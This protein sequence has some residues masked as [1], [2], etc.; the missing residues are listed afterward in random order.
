MDKSWLHEKRSSIRYLYGLHNFLDFAF[1]TVAPHSHR[2]TNDS[3][4]G[5]TSEG[6]AEMERKMRGTS[7]G[8]AEAE[9]KMRGTSEG[10]QEEERKMRGSTSKKTRGPTTCLKT[11]GLRDEERLPIRL[12]MF[13]QPIGCNRAALSTYLGTLARNAHLVPIKYTCW[14]QLQLNESEDW[15]DDMWGTVTADPG[16]GGMLHIIRSDF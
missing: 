6:K 14:K 13:G 8:R 16:I 5:E 2:E 11:H 9:R 1:R 10:R 3:I 12:N 4:D 7:E 15:E